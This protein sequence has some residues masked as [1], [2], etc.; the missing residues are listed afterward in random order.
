[1]NNMFSKAAIWVVI[2][3]VL[4]MVFRQFDSKNLNSGGCHRCLF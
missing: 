4:F 2:A 1:M 3:M